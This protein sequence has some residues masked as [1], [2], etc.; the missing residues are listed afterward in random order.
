[1]K[2]APRFLVLFAL[3]SGALPAGAQQR[4]ISAPQ[5][6]SEQRINRTIFEYVMRASLTN[7]GS[8]TA[9]NAVATVTSTSP[10]TTIVQNTLRFGDVPAN[11]TSPSQDTFTIRHDRTVPFDAAVL[12][13]T[14]TTGPTNP[15]V[16][17]PP[18]P[19]MLGTT[20]VAGMADPNVT[21]EIIGGAS[22]VTGISD[23]SGAF[24]LNVPLQANK[25]NTLFV[26]AIGPDGQRSAAVPVA[27]LQD[28]QPPSLFIDFPAANAEL[29]NDSV[30]V[31]GR[32]GDMLSGY[33][34]LTVNVGGQPATVNV[35]IGNNGT[36]ERS[37]PLVLGV[38]TIG[39]T[40]TD[41]NGNTVTKQVTFTRITPVGP[42]MLQVSGDMQSAQMHG[43]LPQPIVVKIV[44]ENDTPF[45]GKLATFTVTL[46]D[47]RL[48]ADPGATAPGVMVVQV[49]T[50]ANGLARVW[51]NV[52]ADA[53]RANNRVSVTSK[54]I[55]GTVFFFAS[56]DPGPP[57]Q[58]NIGTGNNQKG[59]AG[60]LTAEPLR[61]WV[62]DMCNGI[63][64]LPVTFTVKQGG[65]KVNGQDSV[66]INTSITGHAQVAF[67][68]GP[69][70]GNNVVEANYPNNPNLPAT[71]IATGVVRDLTKLTTFSGLVLDNTSQPVGGA[72]C[73]LT[74]EGITFTTTT[75]IQGRFVFEPSTLNPQR[76]T[77]P[78]G[79]A[80]LFVD[81]T[82]ATL[83]GGQTIPQ[84]S[85][86]FLMYHQVVVANA[87]NSLP[88][89]VLLPRLNPNN[90]K[91]YDGTKDVV[92]TC[93]G[94]AGLQMVIKAGSMR[95]ADGTI[96]TPQ[97]PQ[98][99]SLN[100]VHADNVPMP[101]PDGASPPF[102]WTLQPAMATFDPPVQI[103]Y[104]NMSGLPAGAVAYF[105]SFNH[106]T[107]KFEIIATGHVSIDAS[108]I[109][110]DPGVGISVAG[111]GCNCPPYAVTGD[112]NFDPC[113]KAKEFLDQNCGAKKGTAAG[114]LPC[115]LS[116]LAE[117]CEDPS[118]PPW[119]KQTIVDMAR[120][121]A[122]S[123]DPVAD[124][125]ANVP[126]WVPI[127]NLGI[128]GL[129]FSDLVYAISGGNHLHRDLYKTWQRVCP[130]DPDQHRDWLNGPFLRCLDGVT[131]ASPLA[132]AIGGNVTPWVAG[133]IR[134]CV[135]S[136]CGS[137]DRPNFFLCAAGLSASPS[138][139]RTSTNTPYPFGAKFGEL[140]IEG[141]AAFNVGETF[142][143]I[144]KRTNASGI[145]EDITANSDTRLF[146]FTEGFGTVAAVSSGG[147]LNV[148]G[149]VA[150]G[151][152]FTQTLILIA[153]NGDQYGYYLAEINDSDSDGDG[154]YDSVEVR[155]GLNPHDINDA[156]ADPDNDGLAS[157]AEV[158]IGT[159]P[160]RNDTDGDGVG[161]GDE[162][163]AALDPLNPAIRTLFLPRSS[164]VSANGQ[165]SF[166]D[167][168]LGFTLRNLSAPD[169]FGAGGPG[170]PPDFISDD[171]VRAI[172]TASL[173][174]RSYYGFTE[175][176][177]VQG[178]ATI[179]I[180]EIT[181]TDTPPKK[182]EMLAAAP[183]Q[184]TL[185]ALN[186]TTQVRVTATYADQTIGDVT[187]ATSWTSYRTSN[188]A[189][190][191]VDNNGLVT[192]TGRGIAYLT[193]VNE[194][195]TAVGQI[196]VVPGDPLTTI[197]GF[198][199]FP[200]GS[201][202][203]GVTVTIYGLGLTAITGADGSFSFANVP[204]TLGPLTLGA[205]LV[206][207]GERLVASVTNLIP[208]GGG[209]SDAGIL[210]FA[211]FQD[212]SQTKAVSAGYGHSVALR[213]DGSLWAWGYNYG[214]QVGDGTTVNQLSPVRVGTGNDWA[215]VA[216]GSGHT[217]ALKGDGSLWAWGSNSHG[218]L[219]D[220]TTTDKLSPVR[221][222][223]QNDWMTVVA[224]SGHTIA[225]KVDGSLWAWGYNYD[226]QLGDGTTADKSS[227][228]R[229]GTGNDWTALAVTSVSSHTLARKTDGSL[230]AWG[231]NRYGQL[232]D[233]T[234]VS[235]NN[236]VRI[237]TDND[238]AEV[239]SSYVHTVARKV[240]G[241]LWAWGDN[242]FG[243][244][245]DGTTVN[246]LSPLRIGAEND[247][248]GAIAGGAFIPPFL[249]P[250][251]PFLGAI[252]FTLVRKLDGSLWGWGYNGHGE[253]GDGTLSSQS[254]PVRVGGAD[255]WAEVS[256]GVLHAIAR[257]ADGSLW[258]WGYNH[259][260]QLGDGAT[261]NKLSPTRIDAA[262]D[263]AG[264]AA[265]WDQ[266]VA[267]K[268]DGSLWAWGNNPTGQLGDGTTATKVI[269]VR[270][271]SD[272]NWA[273]ARTRGNGPGFTVARRTD[274]SLW[275]WGTNGNGQLG[276]GTTV[277]KISPVRIGTANDW[278]EANTGWQHAVARKT[279]GSLWTWGYNGSG[280]LGDGT[281]VDRLN[282]IR[283]GTDSDW[284]G[285]GA[286]RDYTLGRKSDGSL[287]AWGY[288]GFGQ[289][290]DG[291]TADKSR[292]VRIG[293]DNDW[294]EAAGY[295]HTVARKTD[296]SLWA[297]G[298]NFFGDVGDGTTVDRFSPVRIGSSNDWAGV[299]AGS[300]FT[301]ARKT[302]G[303]LW[304]WG[305][306]SSG[307]LGDGTTVNKS[308]PS[309]I[310]PDS[311]WAGLAA[312][313]GFS[314]ARKTDGSLWGWGNNSTGQLGTGWISGPIGGTT[315]WGLPTTAATANSNPRIVDSDRDGIPDAFE[316]A[317]GLN[318]SD[319]GDASRDADGDGQ[320]NLQEYLAGTNPRD[321]SSF[322]GIE[323][324]ARTKDAF[325]FRFPSTAGKRYRVEFTDNLTSERWEVLVDNV[326]GTGQSIV[327][328]DP[329]AGE[330]ERGFYRIQ[331]IP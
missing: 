103:Q 315:H 65:G 147:L 199:R 136:H 204:T 236:P 5:V 200:D 24:M 9:R 142:Q 123:G 37:V 274:G 180:G 3:C 278:A 183:D 254:S 50:D 105:L 58:I 70:A 7:G 6:V 311:D 115:H 187:P 252:G 127:P 216:A 124:I 146:A 214:G 173:G 61:A 300:N 131:D 205:I 100:Q 304:A 17:A 323:G 18:S 43:R 141:K 313:S 33:Q 294:A 54:D 83:L 82:P 201:P 285:V 165:T 202:A 297:W 292:P 172:G 97:D 256:A 87:E 213:V 104:P 47:G 66:T 8:A 69:E 154:I 12:R 153:N 27:V 217:V 222:G 326:A 72:L 89:P 291:T 138:A 30:V 143:L 196:T 150:P 265:G 284:A 211:P 75:N 45:A 188:I 272:N 110:T 81:G 233:G 317:N 293:T 320:S 261:A 20:S 273:D 259:F 168:D 158:I 96:P 308:S 197:A 48:V 77:L 329:E 116:C 286:G 1:M 280:Q 67:T 275:T 281:T 303:S 310:G 135:N 113:D 2:R 299:A 53:G 95:R 164:I 117:P 266:T 51:W 14:I 232:G 312:G 178:G 59:E 264:A 209:I 44:N 101:I 98:I 241:S 39:V 128:F 26:A 137:A 249:N 149:V 159:D 305:I 248:V 225:L 29:T 195:T 109:T 269:P 11:G 34:G 157:V 106:D 19:T 79:P 296:G 55:A 331:V 186:Q 38:N 260:G 330:F 238:W 235:R 22:T 74:V 224:G 227:P 111:W 194:G 287:W 324:M 203:A 318:P 229:I 276:D 245:G 139:S 181:L 78:S 169:A 319:S 237:G 223:T 208:V 239:T 290:G 23:A 218:E 155:L 15:V 283:V 198:L 156:N 73:Q 60:A 247:W 253:L 85:Y 28:S 166:L 234:T 322:L 88:T 120:N 118:T 325:R 243:Q 301:L 231:H 210:T 130:I 271:G 177:R 46:S 182:P 170:S 160:N 228:V 244:L 64:N 36:F 174:D 93:E 151:R 107:E 132:K 148:N 10:R 129:T 119:I 289:L 257:K 226:G 207:G 122:S 91:T 4:S 80:K 302:D 49:P 86:P 191:R 16:S 94:M 76:S 175:F 212:D 13:W 63:A 219:G 268:T 221:I 62:N 295:F 99:V 307:E 112:C 133:N 42:R 71:F 56:A 255:V 171:F 240:D 152:P 206:Q 328:T 108:V 250:N 92:L 161:D 162:F 35:G 40:A 258:A 309:R 125:A 327:V 184:P 52:G 306:N 102:T 140:E 277:N 134:D 41:I 316:S 262:K 282:P 90:A 68:L 179:S 25:L 190:A 32:V 145:Q 321:M 267:R 144:V 185:T 192:A 126:S 189:V 57:H 114:A 21:I 230:W 167:T 263:W 251:N 121:S 220:G 84:G 176:F 163:S 270:I 314:L 246:K 288:N 193:V 31:S 215:A 242:A 279:D 298:R